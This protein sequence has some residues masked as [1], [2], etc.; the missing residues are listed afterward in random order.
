[1]NPGKG[2]TTVL[3]SSKRPKSKFGLYK[4][5]SR[6]HSHDKR[7]MLIKRRRRPITFEVGDYVYLK[8]SPMRGV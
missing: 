7:V 5:I 4:A 6:Q 3:T 2:G 1:L 8:V